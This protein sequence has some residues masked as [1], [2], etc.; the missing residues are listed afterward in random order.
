MATNE[1]TGLDS[2]AE[3]KQIKDERKRL[4]EEEK[5][6]QNYHKEIS[7]AYHVIDGANS[8]ASATV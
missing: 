3:K 1:T 5:T 2:K 8:M 7:S 6:W 4:K